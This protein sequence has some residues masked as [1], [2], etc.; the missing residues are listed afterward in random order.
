MQWSRNINTR[1]YSCISNRVSCDIACGRA[2][3]LLARVSKLFWTNRTRF[4]YPTDRLSTSTDGT[5]DLSTHSFGN[6]IPSQSP[7]YLPQPMPYL[8]RPHSLQSNRQ[9]LVENNW[10]YTIPIS[11]P[12]SRLSF[13][14]AISTSF[15]AASYIASNTHDKNIF[16]PRLLRG[17]LTTNTSSL[18][19][20]IKYKKV[21]RLI[22][23]DEDGDE[24]V[25]G[26][27]SKKKKRKESGRWKMA[28]RRRKV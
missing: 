11:R 6:T 2:D 17:T 13:F 21:L 27:W 16:W 8:L 5:C 25:E 24:I 9:I 14:C 22:E 4:T 7:N 15:T 20:S 3:Y 18:K 12:S 26:N 10:P 1:K 19:S 23:V 28:W